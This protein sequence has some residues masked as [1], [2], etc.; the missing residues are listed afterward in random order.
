MPGERNECP[1][2]FSLFFFLSSRFLRHFPLQPLLP[3]PWR[4]ARS[5]GCQLRHVEIRRPD[6]V[7]DSS[8]PL[9]TS[10]RS[11]CSSRSLAESPRP[12][13]RH[14]PAARSLSVARTDPTEATRFSRVC[15]EWRQR[16]QVRPPE[17]QRSV[18]A[19]GSAAHRRLPSVSGKMGA[20]RRAVA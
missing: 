8:A 5:H 18:A 12:R 1:F 20:P 6:R 13:R 19:V 14:G 16:R 11:S 9:A 15:V 7:T 4:S 2:S 3:P 17:P 10:R